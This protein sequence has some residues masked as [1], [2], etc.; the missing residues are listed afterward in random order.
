VHPVKVR[1]DTVGQYTISRFVEL[2]GSI[3]KNIPGYMRAVV[4][5]VA[6]SKVTEAT[7]IVVPDEV[8]G[9]DKVVLYADGT[10]PP[11]PKRTSPPRVFVKAKTEKLRATV[12]TH[13]ATM[14]NFFIFM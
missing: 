10:L 8:K 13:N 1:E 3:T 2:P 11:P 6:S 5:A 7:L 14:S 9:A 4:R 12:A